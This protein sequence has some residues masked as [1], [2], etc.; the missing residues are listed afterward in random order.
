M[1]DLLDSTEQ[2]KQIYLVRHG[3]TSATEKGRVCGNSDIGLT[4]EGLEQVDM[5]ASWFYDIQIDSIFSSPLLRAVQT[6]DAIAKAVMQ[7]TYYKHSG[8]VEKK[9]GDWEGKTYWE[10]RDENQKQW[11][12]WSKDPINYAAPNG[13]NIKDFVA[14]ID[15]AMT[16]I[17]SNY[18]TGNRIVLTTHAGVIRAIII[19]ALNIPVENF[20]R[21][22]VPV[23]SISKIDWSSNYSTLKFTG[24]SPEEYSFA[25]A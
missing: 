1:V 25:V 7:P 2:V 4:A 10:I 16:D 5:V 12:K 13:E 17:L 14:R 6:A 11:E 3:E 19:N 9:E 15:R 18:E 21:I 23:A 8:L 24:L 20:F 22:D